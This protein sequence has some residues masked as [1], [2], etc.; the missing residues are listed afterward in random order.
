[1]NANDYNLQANRGQQNQGQSDQG[2]TNQSRQPGILSM[3]KLETSRDHPQTLNQQRPFTSA[4]N[5]DSGHNFRTS[6][7]MDAK[8]DYFRPQPAQS[9]TK[10]QTWETS[11][12][13]N[14]T[15]S[16]AE[17]IAKGI[18]EMAKNLGK[19]QTSSQTG[20]L[21]SGH[22]NKDAAQGGHKKSVRFEDILDDEGDLTRATLDTEGN[23]S[24]QGGA[25]N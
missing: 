3:G 1:M 14:K 15:P 23:L 4:K 21:T 18:G 13:Q 24:A 8:S 7:L 20:I 9:I 25:R 6:N 2:N 16:C 12:P 22:Q 10:S 17:D 5:I 11:R 19:G